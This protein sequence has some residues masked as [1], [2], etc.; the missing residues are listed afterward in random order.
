M[1]KVIGIVR[2]PREGG[3]T[4]ILVNEAFKVIA[5]EGIGTELVLLWIRDS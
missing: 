3:N 1:S 2:S 5:G 4:E